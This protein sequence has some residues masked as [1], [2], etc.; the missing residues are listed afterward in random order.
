MKISEGIEHLTSN[1][2]LPCRFFK[3][4]NIN[5]LMGIESNS[6]TPL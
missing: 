6:A 1:L 5:V 4:L 3:Y 2:V